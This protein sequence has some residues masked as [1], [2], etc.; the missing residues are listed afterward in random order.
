VLRRG[1][2]WRCETLTVIW[3]RRM[4]TETRGA[5]PRT[6]RPVVALTSSPTRREPAGCTVRKI[7]AGALTFAPCGKAR[8]GPPRRPPIATENAV[9]ERSLSVFSVTRKAVARR[10]GLRRNSTKSAALPA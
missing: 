10:S 1:F 8:S 2:H 6:R 7:W 5:A 9:S 4:S 3:R